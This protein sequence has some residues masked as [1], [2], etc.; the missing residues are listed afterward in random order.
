MSG[1]SKE[2]IETEILGGQKFLTDYES[3]IRAADPAF[4]LIGRDDEIERLSNI[5]VQREAHN[6]LLTGPAGVGRSD[7]I[8][9]LT[10]R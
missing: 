4:N 8:K 3:Y 2:K 9:G 7:I 1:T 10:S 5:L 6:I